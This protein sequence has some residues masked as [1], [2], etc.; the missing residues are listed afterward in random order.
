MSSQ[1]YSRLL[2]RT[3]IEQLQRDPSRCFHLGLD[4]SSRCTGYT[5]MNAVG[6]PLECGT[7]ETQH[8]K[9]DLFLYGQ[10]MHSH[11]KKIREKYWLESSRAINY[12][13][14]TKQ[15][16]WVI[17]VEDYATKFNSKS[18]ANTLFKLSNCNVLCCY[19]AQS[20]L[21]SVEII[22]AI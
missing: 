6:K 1:L 14:E 2:F 3:R 19:E 10:H 21:R 18:S 12:E 20:V 13:K 17:G 22:I 8:V 5:I 9:H 7:I 4:I 16:Q 11:F 15:A